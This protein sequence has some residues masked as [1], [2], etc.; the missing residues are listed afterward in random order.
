MPARRPD[1]G[2]SRARPTEVGGISTD[3]G[4][5][6]RERRCFDGP[7]FDLAFDRN[8]NVL[9]VRLAG[10]FSSEDVESLDRHLTAF[11][12]RHGFA[13][14]IFDFSLVEASDAPQ[15][16]LTWHGRSPQILL[17]Q[18]RSSWHGNNG[19]TSWRAPTPH[20]SATSET[21]SLRLF[22]LSPRLAICCGL[23]D[24]TS[25]RLRSARRR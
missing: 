6:W 24:Q 9:L 11:V 4:I 5:Q 22:A 3:H 16:F 7:M 15:T 10:V 20:T 23:N 12:S 13:R 2:S 17:G 21:W 25:G 8:H 1:A 14:G 18:Q 19:P